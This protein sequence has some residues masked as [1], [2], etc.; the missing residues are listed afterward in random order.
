MTP[1]NN[2]WVVFALAVVGVLIAS[3]LRNSF[4]TSKGRDYM[5]QDALRSAFDAGEQIG[6]ANIAA[7]R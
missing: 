6:R 7:K 3:G 1:H 4:G 2:R 5:S